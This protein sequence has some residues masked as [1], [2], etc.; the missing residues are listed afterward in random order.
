MNL[1]E[2]GDPTDLF[3][4][5]EGPLV[6]VAHDVTPSVLAQLDW[7]RLAALVTDA[8]SWTPHGN[9]GALAARAGSRRSPQRQRPVAP[10]PSS[11][12]TARQARC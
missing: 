1:R 2:A 4:E 11:L 6:L 12:S 3:R 9:P 8:G 10:A 5:L 7:Q